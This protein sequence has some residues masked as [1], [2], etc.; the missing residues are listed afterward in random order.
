[1]ARFQKK[2]AAE[3]EA[4]PSDHLPPPES[5]PDNGEPEQK[6]SPEVAAAAEAAQEAFWAVVAQAFPAALTGD[7]PPD[8]DM[9]FDKA[10]EEAIESW[11]AWNVP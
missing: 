8:A 3:Y 7:F 10:C 5:G 2:L 6:V 9:A 4:D 11:V 1:M